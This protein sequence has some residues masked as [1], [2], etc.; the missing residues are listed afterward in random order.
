MLQPVEKETICVT[1]GWEEK[2]RKRK[3]AIAQNNA[4]K[5][6]QSQPSGARFVGWLF[7]LQHATCC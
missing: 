2:A 1:G 5:R 3:N 4:K 6:A 7:V